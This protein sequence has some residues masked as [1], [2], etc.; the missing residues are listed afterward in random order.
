MKG[1]IQARVLAAK[2]FKMDDM[3][4]SQ[5]YIEGGAISEADKIGCPPMKMN[6][7]FDVLESLRGAIPGDFELTVE[8]RQGG[9]DK[10]T[11][12]VVGAVPTHKN[13]ESQPRSK[14]A[15]S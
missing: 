6:G 8:F 11:Q 2:R 9:G 10:M 3:A 1:K 4:M 7:D 14:P 5:L 12:Y 15:A 13:I